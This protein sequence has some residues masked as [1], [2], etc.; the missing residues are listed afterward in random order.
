MNNKIVLTA[1]TSWYLYN[2]RKGTIKALID[3]GYKVYTVAPDFK[4]AE[5][6]SE[7]GT[8]H[9]FIYM[10]I[11]SRNPFKDI[12]TF[13]SYIKQYKT[14]QP[15]LVLN[16]T[17]KPNI[18][19]TLAAAIM[20][21][22][23]INNISG[24]GNVFVSAGITNRIVKLLYKI[25]Q[26]FANHIFF[27]N[28][29]DMEFFLKKKM[30]DSS[31]VSQLP[32]S[33]VDVHQFAFS[34]L[35]E[36]PDKFILISRMIKEKGIELYALAAEKV[37]KIYTNV[38]FALI[39]DIEPNNPS[40]ISIDLIH[41][42]EQKGIL[43]YLGHTDNMAHVIQHYTAVVLPSYYREGIP[44]SLLEAGALGR[45]VITTD[46]IGC[47]DAVVDGVTGFL[48]QPKDV[49]SLIDTIMRYIRL[50]YHEKEKMGKAGRAYIKQNF[51][52]KIVIDKYFEKI[53]GNR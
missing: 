22:Q 42:W 31:K 29:D 13:F 26:R 24:L 2:F 1:N 4:Y 33:G 19:S 35:P 50:P 47:R 11:H 20:R 38:E 3:T 30:I 39:G 46:N 14:I 48:C 25:S 16:F 52:E 17:P 51:D 37:R 32:G 15:Y 8:I 40:G 23:V 36:E 44:R 9:S 45:P 18:Y 53:Q 49:D 7:L 43:K 34:E 21:R 28:N 10:D 41:E 5:K 12:A 27:Q 6:L